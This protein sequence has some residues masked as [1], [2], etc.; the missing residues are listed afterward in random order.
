MTAIPT[1]PTTGTGILIDYSGIY[2][3]ASG[4]KQFY[5]QSSDGKAYAGAGAVVLDA[6]GITMNSDNTAYI[7]W[8]E[9]STSVATI[10][11]NDASGDTDLF[12]F[13]FNPSATTRSA[14]TLAAQDESGHSLR[15]RILS[16][17][18]S[19]T[20]P[21]N[22]QVSVFSE[23][24]ALRTFWI[25]GNA[26]AAG[27]AS[28]PSLFHISS[29]APTFQMQDTTASAKSLLLTVEGDF[30]TFEEAA[31]TDVMV[32][33]LANARVGILNASPAV[34]L[35][36]TGAITLSG[37]LT[38]AGTAYIGD[39]ANANATLG[40]TI[41]QGA[42]DNEIFALKSSDVA[43]GMTDLTET[44]T[45]FVVRKQSATAGC[46]QLIG[47]SE[48]TRG[49][50]FQA[51][52]TTDSTDKTTSADGAFLVD[53]QLKSSAT[54]TSCGADANLVVFRNNGTAR[55]IFDAEGSGHADVA[56]VAFDTHD[57]LAL[58]NLLNAHLTPQDD[59]LKANFGAWL[60]QSR[61]ELER[62]KLVT[63]G[64]DGHNF[65]NL[66]RM[67]MLEVGAI[68]QMGARLERLEHAMGV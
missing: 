56:W 55:F 36:V 8:L 43:H 19:D 16:A 44:D 23:T 7:R 48:G 13:A 47:Y 66:T 27:I 52:H 51:R 65:I 33:D 62:L 32:L 3:N 21:N 29:T 20:V 17:G 12:L 15:F 58:L 57:D 5:I 45:Y 59:P 24:V 54:V 40:L 41:N 37:T 1:S 49:L 63:F 38:G 9:G 67:H 42:A 64:K 11:A 28:S 6:N 10:L 25:S 2:G 61:D 31:G 14:I 26:D 18:A 46:A 50:H 53:S 68:R 30:A 4:T 60:T 22:R 34:A 39:T 35:D